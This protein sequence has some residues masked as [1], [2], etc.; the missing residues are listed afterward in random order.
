MQFDW[1]TEE[2]GPLT[3][4]PPQPDPTAAPNRRWFIWLSLTAVIL[5][6]GLL[7]YTQLNRRVD[8]AHAEIEAD[9]LAAFNLAQQALT[10]GD[11]ELLTAVLSRQ[12]AQWAREWREVAEEGSYPYA[13]SPLLTGH[14]DVEIVAVRLNDQL[15]EAEIVWRRPYTFRGDNGSTETIHLER[16]DF[17]YK[18]V[19]GWLWTKPPDDYWGGWETWHGRYLT[20]SYPARD[21]AMAVLLAEALEA[22]LDNWCRGELPAFMRCPNQPPWNMRLAVNPAT[23]NRLQ[24]F[25]YNQTATAGSWSFSP[26]P[27]PSLLGRP[28]DDAGRDALLRYYALQTGLSLIRYSQM[29]PGQSPSPNSLTQSVA[30]VSR[31]RTVPLAAARFA[32]HPRRPTRRPGFPLRQRRRW[33]PV[34]LQQRCGRMAAPFTGATGL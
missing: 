22:H 12:D 24:Q 5:L 9:V 33:Q 3:P 1:Q 23:L 18:T 14:G 25:D 31:S 17:Y 20:L 21:M 27:A 4:E 11:A 29:R 32:A 10:Q 2:D 7:V 28:V 19:T 6:T 26:L 15:N 13:I 30:L 16:T 8:A 34:A